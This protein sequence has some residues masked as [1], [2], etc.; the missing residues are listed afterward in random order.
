MY[1]PYESKPASALSETIVAKFGGRISL[2]FR[3][4]TREIYYSPLGRFFD[5]P[6]KINFGIIYDNVRYGLPFGSGSVDLQYIEQHEYFDRVVYIC[7]D[8]RIGVVAEFSF[9]ATFY[10]Q[11]EALCTMPALLCKVKVRR[12]IDRMVRAD[13]RKEIAVFCDARMTGFRPCG[14]TL[15]M[16]KTYRLT[17][18]HIHYQ[19]TDGWKGFLEK[20][21]HTS[22]EFVAESMIACREECA[23]EGNML[24]AAGEIGQGIEMTVR[25]VLAGYC[26]AEVLDV[27]G[28]KM[29]LSYTERFSSVEEVAGEALAHY[30]EIE[31]R[32]SD[33]CAIL[34]KA[35][36]PSDYYQLLGLAMRSFAAN[37]WFCGDREKHWFSV[38]EGNCLFH[39]T[40]DVEYNVALF[41]LMFWPQLLECELKNWAAAKEE[42]FLPHDL[43]GG[44]NVGGCAYLHTMPV[45][46][47]CNFILLVYAYCKMY[48]GERLLQEY[49]S[50]IE[51]AVFYNRSCDMTG[52]GLANVG[53]ANTIDDSSDNVQF[54]QEQIYLGIKEYAAYIAAEEML[55]VLGR[56]KARAVC[57][58]EADKIRDSIERYGWRKDHYAVNLIESEGGL[59]KDSIYKSIGVTG[60]KGGGDAYSI[61]TSNG[62]LYLFM[63]GT[64]CGWDKERLR[65]D[66][67]TARE[68]CMTP[69]GCTHSSFDASNV[70][71]SQNIWRDMTACYLGED[72]SKEI[73]KYVRYELYENQG[74][75]G[76]CFIDTYGWNKLNYYP[77]GIT[78]V[79]LI[80]A[81]GGIAIDAV[82]RRLKLDPCV[83]PCRIPLFGFADWKSGRLPVV[84]VFRRGK[85]VC[86]Y[87]ENRC[88]LGDFTV[89]TCLT[90]EKR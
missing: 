28:E 41:Y 29:K 63:S 24:L 9:V 55:S 51:G 17:D 50:I 4:Q 89:E 38:W 67:L 56:K 26:R 13:D 11:D 19:D 7:R 90:E 15:K 14:K 83:V 78:A 69:Y 87:I 88:L 45:E 58:E 47:N 2:N 65:K 35:D 53:T 62:L 75:R 86:F 34:Q 32:S 60:A 77:R 30:D 3:P 43:G 23:E 25:F 10:P 40:V 57:R 33:F 72:F 54:A 42:D 71:I 22:R 68:A 49:A 20:N 36:M 48:G 59:H 6:E 5:S 39:S 79:G 64:E 85:E 74:G 37:V 12:L 1:L 76:G 82:S 81:R 21:S 66:I 73:C 52:N 80:Y 8:Y 44:S 84:Y 18:D 61:Y 31:K 46:E 16:Q 70:W 27:R